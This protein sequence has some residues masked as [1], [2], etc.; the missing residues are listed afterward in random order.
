[1]RYNFDKVVDRVGTNSIKW[2]FMDRFISKDSSCIPLWIADMDFECAK[3]IVDAIEKRAK[4]LVF[5]YSDKPDS[6]YESVVKWMKKRHN[7]DITK[8]SICV[9]P[10]IV[11]ALSFIVQT[12]TDKGDGVII[13]TPVYGPFTKVVENNGRV[14]Y[15]NRLKYENNRYTIDFEDLEKKA[16]NPSVK[17]MILCS[18]H[19][20]ISR[21]WTKEEL[22]R[23]GQICIDNNVMVVSDEI[24]SDIIYKG[25]K[26]TPFASISEEFANNCI[27]CSAPSK[28][29]NIAG[30][31][32]SN[33][34]IYNEK[35]RKEYLKTLD[36][37][38]IKGHNPFGIVA[39]EAAYNEAEDW[40]EQVIDYLEENVKFV[41]TFLEEK[42]PNIKLVKPEGTFLLWL[43]FTSL[44][45]D[46]SE[47]KSFLEKE[48]KIALDQGVNFGKAGIG[49]ARLNIG[50][51]RKTIELALARLEKAINKK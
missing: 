17:L 21:V 8:E 29:F 3:P 1:M 19:N 39:T 20:P 50:C 12:Y 25:H 16:K 46:G 41:E 22:T 18:P 7:W 10:G 5:G 15:D 2:D 42:I 6:Y 38:G 33:I 14:V 40:V 51:S 35:I 23:I 47:L 28:T 32:T 13:Q 36:R 49:F 26:H 48:A 37:M 24:H 30:L 27:V 31:E 34:I 43:D 44:G 9:T 11:K 45:L 4:H